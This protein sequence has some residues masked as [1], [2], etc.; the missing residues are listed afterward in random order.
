MIDRDS[1][2]GL[3]PKE[4]VTPE[5]V[6]KAINNWVLNRSAKSPINDEMLPQLRRLMVEIVIPLM[7]NDRHVRDEERFLTDTKTDERNHY[8]EITRG[9]VGKTRGVLYRTARSISVK[10]V[11]QVMEAHRNDQFKSHP[12]YRKGDPE[13]TDPA[14]GVSGVR[15]RSSYPMDPDM[16]PKGLGYD[17]SKRG[18]N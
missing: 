4:F 17:Q 3:L 12:A 18:D 8:L 11:D 15:A 13:A 9:I 6:D 1:I 16:N 14:R 7:D 10:L 5:M 2:K